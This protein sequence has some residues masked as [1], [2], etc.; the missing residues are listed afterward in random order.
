VGTFR[1]IGQI[2]NCFDQAKNYLIINYR[3]LKAEVKTYHY[4]KKLGDYLLLSH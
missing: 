2:E 3:K 1:N 4:E